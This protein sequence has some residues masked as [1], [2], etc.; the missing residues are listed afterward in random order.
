MSTDLA[1]ALAPRVDSGRLPGLVALVGTG[2]AQGPERVAVLGRRSLDGPPMTRDTI[3]RIAS[4]TKPITAAAAMSLLDEGRLELDAPVTRWLPELAEPK[5]LREP[6]AD[7][8]DVV[9]A[10]G[11]ITVHQVL[12]STCG[13]GFP[14]SAAPIIPTL[15]GELGQGSPDPG[16]LAAPAEWMRRLARIPLLHQPGAGWTYN[17]SS[18]ILGV[19]IAR[20]AQAPLEQV[21][22]ERIFDPIGMRDTGFHVPADKLDRLATWYMAAPGGPDE[23]PALTAL[24]AAPGYWSTPPAF[25]SGAAGLVS[26]A[27]DWLAFARMLLGGGTTAGGR[28]VLSAEA[29]RRMTSDQVSPQARESAWLFLGGRSWG[30]GGSVD[31]GTKR[32][33][34]PGRYGWVGGTGTSGHVT[35]AAGTAQVLMTQLQLAGPADEAVMGDFWSASAPVAAP[36]GLGR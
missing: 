13:H 3:F 21:L 1:A 27:D 33:H 18:D 10:D 12:N 8:E 5:V 20:A 32:G 4:I 29:V 34:V 31:L 16:R 17:T 9:A 15:M 35:L 22:A 14:G 30:Y 2:G 25:P 26:T 7:I 23:P 36:P 11:P 19:L 6:S 28:R 24:D